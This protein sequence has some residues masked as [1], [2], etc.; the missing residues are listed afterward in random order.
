MRCLEIKYCG[1]FNYQL[2]IRVGGDMEI[3][4]VILGVSIGRASVV[5][6]GIG[7]VVGPL[8][9]ESLSDWRTE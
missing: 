6:G 3:N 9:G 8:T 7:L 1:V 4:G 2:T 5:S